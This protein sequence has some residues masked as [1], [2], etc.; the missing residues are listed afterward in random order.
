MTDNHN[1]NSN[2]TSIGKM[3]S[4]PDTRTGGG[5]HMDRTGRD[6]LGG[7]YRTSTATSP[8]HSLEEKPSRVEVWGWNLYGWCTYLVEMTLLPV[9]F[10]LIISQV[11]DQPPEPP[12]GWGKSTRGFSCR[13]N[14]MRVLVFS[15]STTCSICLFDVL[16]SFGFPCCEC[17]L[18]GIKPKKNVPHFIRIFF[19]VLNVLHVLCL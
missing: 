6:A 15:P 10:P 3:L 17:C 13:T 7:A 16:R 12:Q 8:P 19:W 1:A 18:N 5:V 2:T 11:V 14:E 4:H 9:V